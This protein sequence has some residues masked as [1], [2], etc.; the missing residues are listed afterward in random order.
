MNPGTT[1]PRLL[2][3]FINTKE[4]EFVNKSEEIQNAIKT[5]DGWLEYIITQKE[6]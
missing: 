4:D 2:E 3:D 1:F 5:L 6:K